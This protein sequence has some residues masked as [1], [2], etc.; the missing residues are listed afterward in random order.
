MNNIF[1]I[2]SIS[3]V[4]LTLINGQSDIDNAVKYKLNLNQTD[5]RKGEVVS[6]SADLKILK[7]FYVYSTHPDKSLSPS[8]I[9][10][11]DSSYFSAVGI[12][13]EPK[14]IIKYDPMFEM[15]IGYHIHQV[16]FHQDLKIN[17]NINMKIEER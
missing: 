10:W 2:I 11:E 16:Q 13:K 9:E 1:Q 3:F 15:E 14:P 12:L 8:Y 4:C 7:N 5:L 17:D 6:L